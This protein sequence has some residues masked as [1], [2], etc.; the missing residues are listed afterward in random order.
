[1]D[2]QSFFQNLIKPMG[3]LE[4]WLWAIGLI[5][6]WYG[7]TLVIAHAVFSSNKRD[8]ERGAIRAINVAAWVSWAVVLV[9]GLSA[10]YYLLFMGSV[11]ATAGLSLI[12]S[13]FSMV[14]AVA[15]SRGDKV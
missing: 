14:M 5:A 2:I 1:M 3:T 11:S 13:L 12:V 6:L 7:L 4:Y 8:E 10:G 15:F 9:A